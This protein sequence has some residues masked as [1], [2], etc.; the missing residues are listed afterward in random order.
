MSL[1]IHK[2]WQLVSLIMEIF[3]YTI[4]SNGGGGVIVSR[5]GGGFGIPRY[6]MAL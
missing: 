3:S 6:V 1:M 2:T 5:Y 4:P